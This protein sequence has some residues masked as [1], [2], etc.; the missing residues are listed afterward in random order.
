M[1]E[2]LKEETKLNHEKAKILKEQEKEKKFVTDS[3]M[4]KAFASAP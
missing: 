4:N 3:I 2:D 1:L